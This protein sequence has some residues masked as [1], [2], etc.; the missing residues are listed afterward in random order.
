M[1]ERARFSGWSPGE[2]LGNWNFITAGFL[3]LKFGGCYEAAKKLINLFFN[4][5]ES[6]LVTNCWQKNLRTLGMRL[7]DSIHY[8]MLTEPL[9]QWLDHSNK[10]ENSEHSGDENFHMSHAFFLPDRKSIMMLS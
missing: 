10:S 6:L 3:Q 1:S 2:T 4:S 7:R 9:G 5:P 8:S